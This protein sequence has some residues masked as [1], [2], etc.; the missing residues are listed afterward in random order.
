MRRADVVTLYVI[1]SGQ[2]GEFHF[3][4]GPVIEGKVVLL[5]Y[6]FDEL[7]QQVLQDIMATVEVLGLRFVNGGYTNSWSSPTW[8]VEQ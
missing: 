2:Q 8:Y 6:V 4:C 3:D 1:P 5:S 7:P